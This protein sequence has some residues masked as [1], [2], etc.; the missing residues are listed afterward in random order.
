MHAWWPRKKHLG[1]L[2]ISSHNFLQIWMSYACKIDKKQFIESTNYSILNSTFH[3]IYLYNI[4]R[5]FMLSVIFFSLISNEVLIFLHSCL[6][7]THTN[8]LVATHRVFN[9]LYK[10]TAN[11]II[12]IIHV[13]RLSNTLCRRFFP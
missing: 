2:K 7:S 10:E 11:H 8:C 9:F 1:K 3:P 12:F 4:S 5:S 6:D 13:M